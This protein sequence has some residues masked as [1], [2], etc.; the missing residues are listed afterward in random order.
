[1]VSFLCGCVTSLVCKVCTSITG[2]VQIYMFEPARVRIDR[3]TFINNTAVN[4][5]EG[6]LGGGLHISL[7]KTSFSEDNDIQVS[8]EAKWVHLIKLPI[9]RISTCHFASGPDIPLLNLFAQIGPD[10]TFEGNM[11]NVAGAFS[12]EDNT[13]VVRTGKQGHLLVNHWLKS[14]CSRHQSKSLMRRTTASSTLTR[15]IDQCHSPT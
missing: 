5:F 11:A 14:L 4:D 6:A 9:V 10:V 2:C 8:D 3:T 13:L 12:V 7:F 15:R 1:M